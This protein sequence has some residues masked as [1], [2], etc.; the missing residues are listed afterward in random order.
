MA[1]ILNIDTSS[2]ICSVALA[3]N[4]EIVKG[5]ESKE[6]MDH[7]KSLA[8]FVDQCINYIR[9]NNLHLNAVAVVAGPGSYTGLRI[10]LSLAKGLCFSLDLPLLTLSSLE[11]LAV[12]GIFSYPE[13]S[14]NELI[15]PMLDARRMEVYTAVY[16]SALFKEMDEHPVE[17][18]EN[19]FSNFY[20]KEKI[21]FIGDGID[22]FKPIYKGENGIWLQNLSSHAK[23]MVP[24][25]EKRLKEGKFAN[26]AYSTPNYLKEYQ[27]TKSKPRL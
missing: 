23:F 7:A 26:V 5:F 3:I 18:D 22:K 21:I 16:D 25:A 14:G 11:V 10:G 20:S 19:S 4:G 2:K 15:V 8:P 17:L 1:N 12:R 13:F 24:L 9:E 6:T 27:A